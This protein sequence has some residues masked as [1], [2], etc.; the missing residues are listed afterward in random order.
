MPFK[1][2]VKDASVTVQAFC[3]Q[4]GEAV[5]DASLAHC[6]YPDTNRLLIE[7]QGESYAFAVLHKGE[8]THLYE[9]RQG[10]CLFMELWTFIV[11]LGNDSRVDW[12][13][14]FET[15]RIFKEQF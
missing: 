9:M 15:E 4:C 5:T 14:A 8:C 11:R 7:R 6:A 12:S 3:D 1:I 10:D 13:L 2:V